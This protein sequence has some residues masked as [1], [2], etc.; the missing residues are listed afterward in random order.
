M[1]VDASGNVVSI[2]DGSDGIPDDTDTRYADNL[3]F[4]E[5]SDSS[6]T[7]IW[8]EPER[9]A[10]RAFINAG[11]ELDGGSQIYAFREL[12]RQ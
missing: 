6:L 2:Y 5:V 4:A 7:Q 8:G 11:I 9:D 10:I 3:E 1:Y 12:L